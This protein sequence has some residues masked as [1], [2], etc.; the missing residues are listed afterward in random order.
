MDEERNV[1]VTKPINEYEDVFAWEGGN[2]KL[3]I[4]K[5]PIASIADKRGLPKTLVCHDMNG[6]YLDDRFVQGSDNSDAYRFYH[7]EYLDIFVYFSHHL[8]TIPPPCWTNAGHRHGVKVLGTFITE[9]KYGFECCNVFLET[10]ELYERFASK[11]V[12][13]AEYYRFDGWL[14][15]IENVIEP[16]KVIDLKGFLTCLTRKMHEAIPSS[17]VIWYDSV[18][19]T[20]HLDWQNELNEKNSLFFDACDGIYLNYNW[21]ENKLSKSKERSLAA[22]RPFDVY[23]GIDVFGRGTPGDGG[24]NTREALDMVRQHELSTAIFAQ[25]WVYETHGKENFTI[26][27]NRFWGDLY[28]LCPYNKRTTL[29]LV[30]SFCQGYGHKYYLQGLVKDENPWSNLHMQQIQPHFPFIIPSSDNNIGV[31]IDMD[32]VYQGGTSLC[33]EGDPTYIP[34]TFSLFYTE[35]PL[36]SGIK[37]VLVTKEMEEQDGGIHLLLDLKQTRTQKQIVLTPQ[38]HYSPPPSEENNISKQPDLISEQ[39]GWK[40][41]IYIVPNNV[42]EDWTLIGISIR[43]LSPTPQSTINRFYV[44]QLKILPSD[45]I[46][47]NVELTD[48]RVTRVDTSEES[49]TVVYNIEWTC[50]QYNHVDYYNIYSSSESNN[51]QLCGHA[52]TEK[53][54]LVVNGPDDNSQTLTV[55]PVLLTGEVIALQSCSTCTI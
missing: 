33:V 50:S 1:P 21:T 55:Q 52:S 36:T 9:W 8:V 48:L 54:V 42:V 41:R 34:F 3:S 17:L 7:W 29:P 25:G 39:N 43:C 20:G 22:D 53:Y 32:T 35:I 23:V 6:G 37:V 5:F 14:V 11:L 31:Y 16:S 40:S 30:T 28:D 13:I 49:E 51:Y 10:V 38:I 18:V 27:E 46:V 47:P 26:N 19:D 4:S 45:H 44:G 12:N 2:D 15:N 24:Y